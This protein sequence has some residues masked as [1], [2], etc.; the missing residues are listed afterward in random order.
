MPI[1]YFTYYHSK[2]FNTFYRIIIFIYSHYN[3]KKTIILILNN[4]FLFKKI[5]NLYRHVLKYIKCVFT[6]FL[7]MIGEYKAAGG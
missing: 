5:K 1:L 4:I 3:S 6:S 7:S 2:D